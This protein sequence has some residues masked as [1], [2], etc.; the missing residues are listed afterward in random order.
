MELTEILILAA[1]QLGLVISFA[2]AGLAAYTL[3]LRTKLKR[4]ENPEDD[5]ENPDNQETG[6]SEENNQALQPWQYEEYLSEEIE[7]T[8]Q[9]YH[10]FAG[11]E[12]EPEINSNMAPKLQAIGIR[13]QYLSAERNALKASL[14][15]KDY[16]QHLEDPLIKL[17]ISLTPE[18]IEPIAPAVPEN[19]ICQEELDLLESALRE[20]ET[21][22]SELKTYKTAFLDLQKKWNATQPNQYALHQQLK[23]M[24]DQAENKEQLHAQLDNYQQYFS[25]VGDAFADDDTKLS[26]KQQGT[27]NFD[28]NLNALHNVTLEQSRTIAKLKDELEKMKAAPGADLEQIE[29]YAGHTE[30]L[31]S[32]LNES[33]TCIELL[34]TELDA[35]QETVRSLMDRLSEEDEGTPKDDMQN[36]IEQFTLDSQNMMNTVQMLE[37][38]NEQ[39]REKSE[40]APPSEQISQPAANDSNQLKTQLKSKTED[41]LNLQSEFNELEQRYLALFE[42]NIE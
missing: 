10:M 26:P 36:I 42:K 22:N 5:T 32:M 11:D 15:L 27:K 40:N 29:K 20:A 9:L 2:I 31:E 23:S 38:E 1:T 35:S 30:R 4:L 14:E 13:F 33:S 39:L 25:D 18:P 37:E 16:W 6:E 19:D 41:L 17:A 7:K 12:K 8:K 28:Q 34:E 24:T 3:K 21:K